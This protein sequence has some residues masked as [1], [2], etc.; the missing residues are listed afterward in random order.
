MIPV[1]RVCGVYWTGLECGGVEYW[2][3]RSEVVGLGGGFSVFFFLP[4]CF[5]FLARTVCA[6]KEGRGEGGEFRGKRPPDAT[7]QILFQFLLAYF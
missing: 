4:L 1:A 3:G 7:L 2:S 6:I 5:R